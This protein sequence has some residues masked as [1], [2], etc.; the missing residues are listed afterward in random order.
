MCS[1]TVP[2]GGVP[3]ASTCWKDTVAVGLYSGEIITI[4]GITGSCTAVF[5]GCTAVVRCLAFSS[6][7]TFLA[8]GGDDTVNLWDIQT[9]GVVKT[10]YG[11]T[12]HVLSVSISVDCIVV[13]SGS[14]D[15]TVRLWNIQTEECHHIIQQQHW[16][17]CVQFSSAH[18]QCLISVSGDKVQQ[19]DIDGNQIDGCQI[20]PTCNGYCVALSLDGTQLILYQGEDVVVQRSDSGA[21][22][23]KFHVD[24]GDIRSCCFSPDGR[25]IAVATGNTT[26]V[27]DITS[28][29]PRPIKKLIGGANPI[30]SLVF[31]SPSSLISSSTDQSLK[32]WHI[33]TSSVDPANAYPE[34]AYL[35]SAPITSIILQ[36]KAGPAISSDS[37]GVVKIWDIPTGLCKASFQIPVKDLRCCCVQLVGGRLISAW[38]VDQNIH[39]WDVEKMESLQKIGMPGHHVYI[40][41]ISRDGSKVFCLCRETIQA[42]S[43]QTGEAVGRVEVG[44]S[45]VLRPLTVDGSSIWVHSPL[46]ESLGWD[47]GIPDSPPMQLSKTP[48]FHS[49]NTKWWDVGQ[50]RIID[51]ATGKVIF[52]LAGRFANPVDSWWDGQYLV[53]GCRSGEILILDFNCVPP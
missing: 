2:V 22:V 14:W 34:F 3:W 53:A 15:K 38:Y 44:P 30:T 42:W 21:I 33:G 43:I 12:N 4:D 36:E 27:W 51:A 41:R 31:S 7:G 29:D 26:Y 11:H 28:S 24:Y 5:S 25:F 48:F 49:D 23:A 6:N 8:S 52:Q 47:F 50:S 46:S 18:P 16:V 9:G 13:A 32:F 10:F 45:Q 37:D 40:V 39:I 19:W 35:A 20:S 1:C 17:D